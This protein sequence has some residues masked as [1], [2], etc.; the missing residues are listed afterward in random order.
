MTRIAPTPADDLRKRELARIHVV[1]AQLRMTDDEYRDL[2]FAIARVRS[3][4]DLD[5]TG[6]KRVLDHMAK[7]EKA[8]RREK[9][10]GQV[11]HIRFLWHRLHALGAIEHDST[12]AL[13]AFV[14]RQTGRDAIEWLTTGEARNVIESLKQWVAR[15]EAKHAAA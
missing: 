9:G 15:A 13:K 8:M 5:W 2:L 3:A 11:R 10:D 12:S 1:K 14:K 6:R 7:L 4:A